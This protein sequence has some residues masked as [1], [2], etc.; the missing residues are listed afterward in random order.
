M[1]SIG[2]GGSASTGALLE[3]EIDGEVDGAELAT[4]DVEF[5]E[6]VHPNSEKRAIKAR[7]LLNWVRDIAP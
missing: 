7:S 5:G 4:P 3:V 1:N 2:I 6:S